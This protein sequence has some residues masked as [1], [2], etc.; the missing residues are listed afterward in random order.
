ML[1][2]VIDELLEDCSHYPKAIYKIVYSLM[3]FDKSKSYR[4]INKVREMLVL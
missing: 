2:V 4:D 3:V 1:E